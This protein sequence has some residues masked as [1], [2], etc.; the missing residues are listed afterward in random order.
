MRKTFS[1]LGIEGNVLNLTK[2]ILKKKRQLMN[3]I[4]NSESLNAFSLRLETRE[5]VHFIFLL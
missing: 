3:V 2:G 4:L 5:H 1:H